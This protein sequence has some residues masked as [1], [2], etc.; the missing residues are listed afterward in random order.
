MYKQKCYS[1]IEID[2]TIYFKLAKERSRRYAAQTITDVDY[3]DD[4]AFMAN[5]LTQAE[6]LWHTLKQEAA[7]ISNV[8]KT[9]YMRFDQSGDISTL[10]GGP[11]KLVDKF[12]YL[13]SSVSSTE[14]GINSRLAKVWKTIDRLS[15]IW[16]SDLTDKIKRNF[17]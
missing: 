4:I 15:V 8:D 1:K 9:E 5:T 3:A 6:S 2:Q 13:G 14:K 10:K 7:G 11:L 16:N 12:I 17:F